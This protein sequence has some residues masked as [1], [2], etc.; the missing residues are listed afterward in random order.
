[1]ALTAAIDVGRDR[2]SGASRDRR[3]EE[4]THPNQPGQTTKDACE[5]KHPGRQY[6]DSPGREMKRTSTQQRGSAGYS[7][8]FMSAGASSPLDQRPSFGDLALELR[9]ME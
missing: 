1:M 8:G 5:P 4:Q 2:K 3:H 7:F 6:S 9:T